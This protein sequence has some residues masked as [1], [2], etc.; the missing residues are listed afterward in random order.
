MSSSQSLPTA[1]V[2]VV[3]VLWEGGTC[4][5][6][7]LKAESLLVVRIRNEIVPKGCDHH[8]VGWTSGVSF[9]FLLMQFQIRALESQKRQQ[10]IVLRRKTQ[11]VRKGG[12]LLIVPSS[13]RDLG[14]S[15]RFRETPSFR[16]GWLW[17]WGS[18]KGREGRNQVGNGCRQQ[19]SSP[20]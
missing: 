16:Q 1:P 2:V 6:S 18:Q 13:H 14:L 9:S 17:E 20:S 15:A 12:F 19:Q 7:Q 4:N 5:Q 11:E 10:E 3:G 8:C